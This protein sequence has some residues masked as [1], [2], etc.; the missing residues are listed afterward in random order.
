MNEERK[1]WVAIIKL[2]RGGD[3]STFYCNTLVK[4]DE[5]KQ[6]IITTTNKEGT[7]RKVELAY[8]AVESIEYFDV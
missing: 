7:T 2:K 1:N 5:N 8:D 6:Y 3:F 4:S